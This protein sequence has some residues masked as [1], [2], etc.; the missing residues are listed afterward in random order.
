MHTSYSMRSR[1]AASALLAPA[2][3]KGAA[4]ARQ[5]LQ[6]LLDSARAVLSTVAGHLAA[7]MPFISA[8]PTIHP[9]A[10]MIRPLQEVMTA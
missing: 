7:R 5:L 3:S 1:A 9:W 4:A 6:L 2:V 8:P 10:S